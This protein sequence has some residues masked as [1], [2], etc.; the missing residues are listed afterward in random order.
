MSLFAELKR[1]NV[2]RAAAFYAASAWLLVQVATQVFPF[3][4]IAEWVVRW[5]VVAA[6]IGFPFALLSSWFYEWTPQGLQR[7]SAIPPNES[8]TRRTGKKL[9]RWITVILAL[10]VVLLL[11]D[12]FVL[13]KDAETAAAPNVHGKSIAILPFDNLSED[14][15][16]AYFAE[17]IQDEILT[18]LS[19]VAD[20]KVISRT[21]TQHFKSS[22]DNL[23][24]IAKQLGVAHIL[25]GSVQKA[26]D[27]IRVN[28]QLINALTDTHLWADTFD[29]KLTD[30]FAVETEIAKTIADMLQAKLS[31]S[32]KTAMAKKPTANP[33]A[34]ELYLQGRFF[35]NKR[36]APDL[37]KS[38]NYFN[39]AIAK[40]P[41]Y[42]LAY[43][44]LAQAWLILPAYGGGAPKDCVPPAEAAAEKALALDE[45]SPD[46]HAA[47]GM[48]RSGYQFDFPGGRK[49]Y[50]RALQLNPNDATSHHW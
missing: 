19:K 4:H 49:E 32:E 34:Y 8:I 9:D 13:H 44:A 18:R 40:D 23:P 43:A 7:E 3:F 47:L 12:K 24:Q 2:L 50:E 29:R 37:R 46:A 30:I 14:K 28:V 10:A 27:Q 42:A 17:G 6:V 25:E 1:R 16:N 20:L 11:A 26:N 36:T 31:G 45:T 35:W 15:G 41:D 38:I 48:L 21:S 33:E 5:I 22:P 39:Q